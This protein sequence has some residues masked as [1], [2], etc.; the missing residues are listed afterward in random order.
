ML[1]EPIAPGLIEVLRGDVP[2]ERA[3]RTDRGNREP[4]VL[5]GARRPDSALQA[6]GRDGMRDLLE[7]LRRRYDLIVIDTA[8]LAAVA[9]ARML[10]GQADMALVLARWNSTPQAL[11]EQ[12]L[13]SLRDAGA[14]VA[15][16]VL[17]QV[18]IKKYAM[19]GS[20]EARLASS[21]LAAYYED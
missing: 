16:T 8:P 7:T 13:R 4:D 11:V 18:D 6:L 15:G 12:A 9:D 2:L 21:Q 5:L 20:A 17:T 19:H 1:G 14:V 3:L 10:A